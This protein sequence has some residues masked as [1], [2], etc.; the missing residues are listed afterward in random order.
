MI[1][2]LNIN[3]SGV[4]TD[5]NLAYKFKTKIDKIGLKKKVSCIILIVKY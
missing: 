5:C 4:N 3:P 2:K 1:I